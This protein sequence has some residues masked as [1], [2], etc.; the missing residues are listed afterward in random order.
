MISVPEH[1]RVR[2]EEVSSWLEGEGQEITGRFL[3]RVRGLRQG[4]MIGKDDARAFLWSFFHDPLIE[5][6]DREERR[7]WQMGMMSGLSRLSAY[8]LAVIVR[9]LEGDGGSFWAFKSAEQIRRHLLLKDLFSAPKAN[10]ESRLRRYARSEMEKAAWEA[11]HDVSV[12]DSAYRQ[13]RILPKNPEHP[14][15]SAFGDRYLFLERDFGERKDIVPCLMVVDDDY[16]K[17]DE[18][19]FEL[20]ALAAIGNS[21]LCAVCVIDPR[22]F[23]IRTKIADE[24]VFGKARDLAIPC[25]ARFW[26][27]HVLKDVP[28]PRSRRELG[29]ISL[30]GEDLD[31][32]EKLAKRLVGVCSLKKKA[33]EHE[34][35]LRKALQE[36]A[37]MRVKSGGGDLSDLCIDRMGACSPVKGWRVQEDELQYMVD[38][39]PGAGEAVFSKIKA[40]PELM[41]AKLREIG[42][43]ERLYCYG[44]PDTDRIMEYC[45][46]NNFS[47]PL[48]PTLMF[49]VEGK[50]AA[51][52]AQM[53]RAQM[54]AERLVLEAQ[55]L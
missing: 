5:G 2:Y 20:G 28:I 8:D 19:S 10:P 9:E 45:R 53:E 27:E 44:V 46:E 23:S 3:E 40:D 50:T 15:I 42:V 52:K 14:H 7:R 47:L 43:D 35:A 36:M 18:Y 41:E 13:T 33:E 34:K 17:L 38:H 49:R 51:G 12:S 4:K 29:S 48:R 1:A 55:G 24:K 16:E 32:Y 26:R 22:E 31:R 39:V 6:M 25:A 37:R 30:E 54:E 11:A 21:V